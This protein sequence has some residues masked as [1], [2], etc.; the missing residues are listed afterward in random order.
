MN[1]GC[2]ILNYACIIFIFS[3]LTKATFNPKNKGRR[4]HR[5]PAF[6]GTIEECMEDCCEV[7][8]FLAVLLSIP[9]SE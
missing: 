1:C 9:W 5:H 6:F 4:L 7:N 3:F 8:Q 2:S